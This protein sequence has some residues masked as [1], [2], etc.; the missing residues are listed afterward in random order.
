MIH[1]QSNN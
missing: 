1:D